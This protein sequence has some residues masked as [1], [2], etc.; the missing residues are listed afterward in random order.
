MYYS[1]DVKTLQCISNAKGNPF[2]IFNDEIFWKYSITI[3]YSLCYY[4]SKIIKQISTYLA[5]INNIYAEYYYFQFVYVYVRKSTYV[6]NVLL[7]KEGPSSPSSVFPD[8][9]VC[10]NRLSYHNSFYFSFNM[11][12]AC[13]TYFP[14][15][16]VCYPKITLAFICCSI[17]YNFIPF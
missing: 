16:E 13:S 12:L 14:F 3:T 4:K 5:N 15:F 2:F 1:C 17:S 6:N 10:A 9:C 8:S 7:L 11:P